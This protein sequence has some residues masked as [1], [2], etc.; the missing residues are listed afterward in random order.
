MF[1]RIVHGPEPLM[2]AIDGVLPHR[3]LPPLPLVMLT[4]PGPAAAVCGCVH[5]AGTSSDTCDP[6]LEKPLLA[7]VKVNV[8]VFVLPPVTLAGVTPIWP[9]P[10]ASV[11]EVC[12][13]DP[14]W[15]PVAVRKN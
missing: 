3:L 7:D 13:S 10:L 15:S 5:P 9:S 1:T 11:N 6:A 4:N 2:E 8:N 12:A 14:D